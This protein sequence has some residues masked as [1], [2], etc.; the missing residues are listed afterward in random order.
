MRSGCYQR[1]GAVL[2]LHS[3]KVKKTQIAELI[4]ISANLIEQLNEQKRKVDFDSFDVTV[5][6]LIGMFAD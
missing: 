4:V 1:P 6:E 3:S 5:K 2:N